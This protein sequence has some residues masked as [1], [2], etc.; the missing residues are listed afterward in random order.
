AVSESAALAE[1]NGAYPDWTRAR[2]AEE[3]AIRNARTSA[4]ALGGE[5]GAWA[6]AIYAALPAKDM[7]Q[8]V[9]T[10]IAF[11]NDVSSV[12]RLG[13]PAPGLAPAIGAAGFGARPDG[14]F[15]RVLSDDARA[16]LVRLGYDADAIAAIAL[17]V[18]GRRTLRG[19]PGVNLERLEK[20][21]LTEPALE[22]IE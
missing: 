18:E 6:Q 14:G 9:S 21:G 8:R 22:A 16:G 12:Q 3:L 4:T 11:A 2:K 1:K 5:I 20:I 13:A 17:H 7:S 19:A 10:T 15:G